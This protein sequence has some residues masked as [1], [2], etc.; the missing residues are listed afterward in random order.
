MA[1]VEV[2][3]L[4]AAGRFFERLTH[5][6]E[7]KLTHAPELGGTRSHTSPFLTT[8]T[9]AMCAPARVVPTAAL[10]VA[11]AGVEVLAL[12]PP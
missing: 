6:S 11:V 8:N 10:R 12:Q 5:A 7:L 4:R 2:L 3:I 9:I 1:G